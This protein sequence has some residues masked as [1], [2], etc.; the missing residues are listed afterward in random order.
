MPFGATASFSRR[1]DRDPN[2]EWSHADM[3]TLRQAMEADETVAA[4][5]KKLGRTQAAV[6]R[7]LKQLAGTSAEG[8]SGATGEAP[9]AWTRSPSTASVGGPPEKR[10]ATG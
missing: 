1:H 9:L 10:K 2:R 3:S 5:A 7:K 4:V 8:V 6:R